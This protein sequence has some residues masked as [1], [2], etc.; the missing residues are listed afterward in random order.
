M[1]LALASLL[2][3]SSTATAGPLGT[4]GLADTGAPT[5]NTGDIL[6]STTFNIGDLKTTVSQTGYF[7]GMT[8]QVFGAVTF[9]S[10]KGSSFSFGDTDFGTFTSTSISETT[11]VGVS[12]STASFFILGNWTAGTFGGAKGTFP[13]SVTLSFTQTPAHSGAISDS[14]TFSVPPT[15]HIHAPEP[16]SAVLLGL[17]SITVVGWLYR[18]RKARST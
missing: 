17:S 8:A 13:A 18:R 11:S 15:A 9:H 12:G 1:V 10:T 16:S 4:Q 7:V 6:T 14:G 5:T 3:G 2:V